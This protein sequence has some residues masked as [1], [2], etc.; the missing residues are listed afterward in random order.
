MSFPEQDIAVVKVN[1]LNQTIFLIQDSGYWKFLWKNGEF[2]FWDGKYYSKQEEALEKLKEIIHNVFAIRAIS[3]F[4]EE[5]FI[6]GQ[7]SES[8][9]DKIKSSLMVYLP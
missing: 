5:W 3:D 4:L 6:L 2:D 1:Y 9:V 7:L 8:E